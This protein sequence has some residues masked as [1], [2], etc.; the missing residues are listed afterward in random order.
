MATVNETIADLLAI[1][2]A[3]AVAIVDS[4]SGMV[5]GKGG[6]GLNLDVAAAS[7]TEMLR[8]QM[9]TMK[10]LGLKDKL[11]DFLI[12]LASQIHIIHPLAEK[13]SLYIYV[14]VD[15][16][17]GNLAMARYRINEIEIELTI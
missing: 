3:T 4:S 5:L 2:G 12:T 6:T 9:K 8:A 11:E 14:A 17:K 1:D 13:P 16:A 15:T 7:T 10:S